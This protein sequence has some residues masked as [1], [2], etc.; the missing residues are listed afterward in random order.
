MMA[1][2]TVGSP[3]ASCQRATGSWL[4]KMVERS[5]RRSSITS[6]TSAAWSALN[7][8]RRKSSLTRTSMRAQRA[9]ELEAAVDPRDG[10][11]LE[12]A[13]CPQVKSSVAIS[14]GGV[15]KR[16]GEVGLAEPG[17][18]D[19]DDVMVALDEASLGE[20]EELR[21]GRARAGGGSRCPRRRRWCEAW[22]AFK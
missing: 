14:D 16:A 10:E 21:R 22:P 7:G 5:P 1:S 8:L 17:R 2:A 12:H 20:A 4:V 11:L 6:S 13:G 18:P 19:D 15:G 9:I 3:S